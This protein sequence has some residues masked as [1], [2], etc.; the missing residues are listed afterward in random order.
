MASQLEIQIAINEAIA[1]R[2]SLLKEQTEAMKTQI[3]QA[4]GLSKA[5]AGAAPNDVIDSI[6]K[7][8]EALAAASK[9]AE[10][11]GQ[12]G[13]TMGKQIAASL[14]RSKTPLTMVRDR[15]LGIKKLWSPTTAA[16]VGFVDGLISGFKLITNT[17]TSTASLIGSIASGF[18]NVG[19]A[20]VAMPFRSL[21]ALIQISNRLTSIMEAIATATEEVRKQFGD[22]ASGP[23]QA[24][25]SLAK[26]VGKEFEAI[27]LGG[28]RIFGSLDERIRAVNQVATEMGASF[29]AFRDE[30]MRDGSALLLM[31]RGLGLTGEVMGFVAR[32]AKAFGTSIGTQLK[33]ITKAAIDFGK[34]FNLSSK[35]I[36][37]DIGEMIKDVRNFANMGPRELAKVS[38]YAKK[39]SVDV[40]ELLGVIDKFDTFEDA[41][42]ATAMLSQAFGAQ[43]DAIKLMKAENPVD[44]IDELRRAF[45]AAGKSADSLTRQE[46][47]LLAQ[48]TGLD[49]AA[50]R[51]VF[52]QKNMSASMADLEK[53]GKI[54]EQ[55]QLS[56]AEA[57]QSLT[58]SIERVIKPF[59]QFV[60]FLKSFADGFA[61]G[62]FGAEG[63]RDML[64]TLNRALASTFRV[65]MQVGKAFHEIFPGITEMTSAL[66]SFF[67]SSKRSNSFTK[68]ID[69]VSTAFKNFFSVVRDGDLDALPKLMSDLNDGFFSFLDASQPQGSKFVAGFKSFVASMSAIAAGLVKV[70]MNG[71]AKGISLVSVMIADFLSGK[72]IKIDTG[73]EFGNALVTPIINA[74]KEGWPRLRDAF[75]DLWVILEPVVIDG[76]IKLGMIYAATMFGAAFVK[77][78]TSLAAASLAKSFVAAVGQGGVQSALSAAGPTLLGA[79]LNPAAWLAAS[80]VAVGAL[81]VGVSNGL[82]K[83]LP[84]FEAEMGEGLQAATASAFAGIANTL[85][86]GLIS[87]AKSMDVGRWVSITAVKLSAAIKSTF[88][89]RVA[90][91]FKVTFGSILNVWNSVGKLLKNVVKG[92]FDA[93]GASVIDVGTNIIKYFA[94]FASKLVPALISIGAQVSSYLMFDLSPRVLSFFFTELLPAVMKFGAKMLVTLGG[95]LLEGV[96]NAISAVGTTMT[97]MLSTIRNALSTAWK[98]IKDDFF[99][100]QFWRSA[101]SVIV[102]GIMNA[103]NKLPGALAKK[104]NEAINAVKSLFSDA[105]E[106]VSQSYGAGR[107]IANGLNEGFSEGTKFDMSADAARQLAVI[108]E[109][110]NAMMFGPLKENVMTTQ[111]LLDDVNESVA[112]VSKDASSAVL[113]V[114]AK[115]KK[116][117][118]TLG[119]KDNEITIK[120]KNMQLLVNL[121][122]TMEADTLAKVLSE[123]G[124]VSTER[125]QRG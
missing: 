125:T 53:Q 68:F 112:N 43:A 23:G 121:N 45:F 61:R 79:L 104:F 16:V 86:F 94:T 20:I 36:S 108:T 50:A 40:K 33:A 13:T 29:E 59:G 58:N 5:W 9:R 4:T 116:M 78:L 117:G 65:G 47:K 85:S 62:L 15:I 2:T 73:S 39:L 110:Q 27:G 14:L 90:G 101:G 107:A 81:G 24:V 75:S 113:D 83:F 30:M 48:T 95:L 91:A 111:K 21:E 98:F 106:T 17:L 109:R 34:S 11:T 123:H 97:G 102:D 92:D 28:Y 119:I 114:N 7:M 100:L 69:S 72:K 63:F 74:I 3:A 76:A 8:N 103:L 25:I 70:L 71:L 93:I 22:L 99:T 49:E 57:V 38:V 64:W 1:Q 60:S 96:K 115:L 32:R 26:N 66:K 18:V 89:P 124:L 80:I 44:R 87:T 84:A 31:Q 56:T 37:R 67:D 46:L 41:A 35:T 51:T 42:I 122:V 52:S 82:E 120:H 19:M 105:S 6:E 55:R 77:S 88:G 54:S 12:T 10:E 118:N